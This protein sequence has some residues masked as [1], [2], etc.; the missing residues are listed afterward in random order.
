MNP[1]GFWN[2]KKEY[3][4]QD[5]LDEGENL[6]CDAFTSKKNKATKYKAEIN[7]RIAFITKGFHQFWNDN[8]SYLVK[9]G[10]L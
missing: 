6:D 1:I 4:K 5:D 10:A 3:C 2:Y 8:F 9:R 7:Y